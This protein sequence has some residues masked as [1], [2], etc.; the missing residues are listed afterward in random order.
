MLPSA[1]AD[2]DAA[3]QQTDDT[4]F[5]GYNNDVPIAELRDGDQHSQKRFRHQS[6]EAEAKLAQSEAQEMAHVLP[7]P[8]DC[9]SLQAA[10]ATVSQ[11][12]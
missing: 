4:N 11:I 5:F 9:F 8:V 6:H 10:T 3:S 12:V 7:V 2:K 1:V